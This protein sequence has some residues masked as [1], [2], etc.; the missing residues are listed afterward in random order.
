MLAS[1]E[2]QIV[3]VLAGTQ[4]VVNTLGSLWAYPPMVSK[5]MK[6]IKGGSAAK[7]TKAE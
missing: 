5:A 1:P 2:Q 3:K 4:V 6:T 7:T